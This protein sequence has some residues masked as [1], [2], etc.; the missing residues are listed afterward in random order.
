MAFMTGGSTP[1]RGPYGQQVDRALGYVLANAR[2]DGYILEPNTACHG[3]MYNHGF[4]TLL[5]A[6][7]YGMSSRA[8]LR[9]KLSKAVKLII[10]TQNREGG[11]RYGPER[12]PEADTSVTSCELVAL[13][14]AHNAG[15][16]V[17]KETFLRGRDYLMRCQNADG[18]FMYLLSGRPESDFARS[19]AVLVALASAGVYQ[20]PKVSKGLDYLMQFLPAEGVVRSESYYEYGHYYAV[21]AMWLCGGP[22]WARWYPAIR[23]ELV[24]RQRPDGSWMSSAEGT[25]YDT[26]MCLMVLQMPQNQLPIFQR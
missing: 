15:L 21:Q 8:D 26:A 20:E 7:C 1:G 17:P 2:P 6:E 4:A 9:E 22:R 14:A 24:A 16:H 3:P 18:G 23:D 5:L 10:D 12:A 11:W 19:A 13:R 25:E